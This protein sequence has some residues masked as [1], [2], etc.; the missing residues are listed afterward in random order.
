M[1]QYYKMTITTLHLSLPWIL[2]VPLNHNVKF[3]LTICILFN[4]LDVC[5]SLDI[6]VG[7]FHPQNYYENPH[8]HF[9]VVDHHHH[10]HLHH[11]QNVEIGS[12]IN[13]LTQRNIV[14][15]VPS[16]S[17]SS[18]HCP[19][20]PGNTEWYRI[21]FQRELSVF[22]LSD[23]HHITNQNLGWFC[24]SSLISILFH[25]GFGMVIFWSNCWILYILDQL[26]ISLVEASFWW[27]SWIIDLMVE[28]RLWYAE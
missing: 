12:W 18:Y 25:F 3:R 16:I 10:N 1:V 20:Y 22:L 7:G 23:Q 4:L 24:S 6:L 19:F 21:K 17:S 15:N 28:I 8:Y 5:L 9:L 2:N 13:F 11:L 26:Q 14:S 27:D